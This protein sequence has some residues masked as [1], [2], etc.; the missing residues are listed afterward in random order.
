MTK[1]QL[2]ETA[3]KMTNTVKKVYSLRC[4]YCDKLDDMCFAETKEEVEE[5][6][7]CKH[8]D[9]EFIYNSDIETW[10]KKI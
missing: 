6:E 4:A 3:T 5:C 7:V 9:K 8:C 10:Y 2:V 1:A